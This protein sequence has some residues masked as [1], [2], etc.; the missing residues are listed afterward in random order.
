MKVPKII[1]MILITITRLTVLNNESMPKRDREL[2]LS[3]R[4][5]LRGSLRNSQIF[6]AQ[7]R[8]TQSAKPAKV[9]VPHLTFNQ[10]EF[11]ERFDI[12]YEKMKEIIK[13]YELMEHER[14]RRFAPILIK[15]VSNVFRNI[16]AW[17]PPFLTGVRE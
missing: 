5:T 17:V 14:K 10:I 4:P 6:L 12:S 16:M 9:N 7:L 1:P 11:L 13:S 8:I 3:F 15:C 2:L